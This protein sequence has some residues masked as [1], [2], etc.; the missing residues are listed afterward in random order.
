M[1][2]CKYKTIKLI[3][4]FNIFFRIG[5]QFRLQ[6]EFISTYY[7]RVELLI[8]KLFIEMYT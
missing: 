2:K 5:S 1:C 4:D 6:I 7:S 8:K 3:I